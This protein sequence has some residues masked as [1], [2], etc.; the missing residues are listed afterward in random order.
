MLHPRFAD[1]LRE[2]KD[3][4]F[5]INVLSNL[6]LLNDEI[7]A[8]MKANRLSSVQVSLYSLKPEV[9]EAVTCL[10]GSFQKTLNAILRL[11]EH[12]IPLQI[13]C[14]VM[15]HNR[16]CYAEVMEW[17]AA[18][19]VRAVTDYILMARYDH[20]AD[21]LDNRLNLEEVGEMINDIIKHDADYQERLLEAD[22]DEVERRDISEDIV[23]GVGI[24][25]ACMVANG[26]VYPC[27]GWQNYVIGNAAQ[28]PLR[29]LWRDAPAIKRLRA[30]RRK[31]FPRCIPC[32]DRHF[33]AM[34]MVR[35][36]NES[37][38]GDFFSI[39]EHFCRVAALNRN[40]VLD[41]KAKLRPDDGEV[42]R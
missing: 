21:N 13:S 6:T 36:A 25:S 27:A 3:Y 4:D 37:P 41:W 7:L 40:I 31:D 9:H 11:I 34:C 12:D 10:P 42:R 15:R 23:C 2:A 26:N 16:A 28:V 19:K 5:S 35:N 22:F 18:H 33:C 38:D 8:E 20:S 32:E 39:N 29:D 1:F 30:L 17:A 24:S 14:P